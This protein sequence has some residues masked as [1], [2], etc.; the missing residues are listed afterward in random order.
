M[1]VKNRRIGEAAARDFLELHL[2]AD[3]VEPPVNIRD[4]AR[5]AGVRVLDF[6]LPPEHSGMLIRKNGRTVIVVNGAHHPRRQRFSIAHELG[7]L[8]IHGDSGKEVFHRHELHR[9]NTDPESQANY[10]AA[11]VLM[12]KQL[13]SEAAASLNVDMLTDRSV[14]RLARMFD[15]SIAAMTIR[16][17]RL[18]FLEADD[19]W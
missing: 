3:I 7:H 9:P 16:L 10:F 5:R 11:E 14:L 13:V 2:G 18:G 4:V 15:V 8:C 6:D 12:P 17:Q 19:H 1:R